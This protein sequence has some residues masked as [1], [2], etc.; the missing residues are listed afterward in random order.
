MGDKESLLEL[1]MI[2]LRNLNEASP[3]THSAA[4][5]SPAIVGWIHGH[6]GTRLSLT[7]RV[8]GPEMDSQIFTH[9][10][11]EISEQYIM[12]WQHGARIKKLPWWL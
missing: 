10:R 7:Y 3:Y 1:N 11:F 5:G 6:L 9:Q 12:T 4:L 2:G 8:P